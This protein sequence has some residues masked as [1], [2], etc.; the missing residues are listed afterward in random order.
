[1]SSVVEMKQSSPQQAVSR[2]TTPAVAPRAL[3][4]TRAQKAAVVPE[5]A[6][7][8]FDKAADDFDG[9]AFRS[10]RVLPA[11][12][13]IHGAIHTARTDG[14]AQCVMHTHETSAGTWPIIPARAR[15]ATRAAVEIKQVG[16]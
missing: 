13:A 7:M 4:L 16:Q 14:T 9:D 8:I 2:V 6:L 15:L 11:A 5:S 1:M 3:N 12:F 10:P